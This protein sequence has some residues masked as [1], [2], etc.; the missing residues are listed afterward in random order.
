MGLKR[1]LLYFE[2]NIREEVIATKH[3]WEIDPS[4]VP[5]GPGLRGAQRIQEVGGARHC[6]KQIRVYFLCVLIMYLNNLTSSAS[7]SR[8]YNSRHY[9]CVWEL[10]FSSVFRETATARFA[11]N[12][13]VH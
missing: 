10:F 7:N 2:V 5:S 3:M 4:L 6:H 12:C 11:P 9:L 1:P 13:T 8:N